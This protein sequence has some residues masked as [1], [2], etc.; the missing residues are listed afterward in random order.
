MKRRPFPPLKI[1][2]HGI[3][4][5]RSVSTVREASECLMEYWPSHHGKA[6]EAALQACLDAMN[7]KVPPERVREALIRAAK[8]A[9]I[10]VIA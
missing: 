7:D 3:S 5:Y 4:T 6:F 2:V 8:E 9:K 1:A 10:S